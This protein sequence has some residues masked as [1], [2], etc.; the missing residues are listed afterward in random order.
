[1]TIEEKLPKGF[2]R[3]GLA[4]AAAIWG[5]SF[6][7][8][9]GALDVVA[10]S[11]LMCIR[12]ALAALVLGIAFH[13]RLAEKLDRKHL[14]AA[15]VVGL[16]CG[17]A[18]IV[19]NIGLTTIT[20]GRNA[21]LT[22]MYSVMVPFVNWGVAKKRPGATNV[23]AAILAVVGVGLLS[24]GDD[25]SLKL[26]TGDWLSLASAVLY[27][28]QIVAYSKLAE[29][30]DPMVV[31]VLQL[32]VSSVVAF[33]SAQIL[34]ETL[35]VS[36]FSEPGLWAALAY[37][38]LL[39]SA[40]CFV[41]QNVGQSNVPPARASLLLSLES[42]FAVIASILFYG[43]VVTFRLACGFAT[44]FVAVLISEVGPALIQRVRARR[45]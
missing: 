5:G 25:M 17:N 44:I 10:P 21:F 40:L 34:G 28:L 22:A 3:L 6:V 12:F 9:K 1:M 38:V 15:L 13:R 19:Q 24:L 39:S 36:A 37:L 18:F 30:C 11:W 16:F 32:A 7:V 2:W 45:A 14:V 26:A 8:I 33:V 43:E 4:L 29:D 35:D 23:V 20:P 42:V 31:T 41:L 27:A